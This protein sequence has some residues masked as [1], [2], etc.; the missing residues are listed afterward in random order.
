MP[1]PAGQ[2]RILGSGAGAL[3]IGALDFH[4][5]AASGI[6]GCEPVHSRTIG[7]MEDC[8]PSMLDTR[9]TP[10]FD[11]IGTL[12]QLERRLCVAAVEELIRLIASPH[13]PALRP[14]QIRGI[15]EYDWIEIEGERFFERAYSRGK[16]AASA[17]ALARA[18]GPE[19]VLDDL[20]RLHAGLATG[21]PAELHPGA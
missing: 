19:P 18:I 5:N 2:A 12:H 3:D 17:L 20:R 21:A 10:G 16:E 4:A 8:Q 1:Q 13:F 14:W 11:P 9:T 15:G 7:P 6:S